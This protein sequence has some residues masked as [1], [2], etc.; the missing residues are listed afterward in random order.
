M[1]HYNKKWVCTL[2]PM[3]SLENRYSIFLKSISS[4]LQPMELR[5]SHSLH[6]FWTPRFGF[7][8]PIQRQ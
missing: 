2:Q 6:P 8:E 3:P 1:W 5:P 4:G 7:L